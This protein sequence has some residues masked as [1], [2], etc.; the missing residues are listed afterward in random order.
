MVVML[1]AAVVMALA[2]EGYTT[3]AQASAVTVGADMLC[4]AMNEARSSA[5]AQNMTVEVRIYNVPPQ[6]GATPAY[7]ALQ[8]HWI[9]PDGTMPAA[10]LPVRLSSEVVIDATT[11]HSPLIASNT[12]TL[13]IDPADPL[14]NNQARVFHYLPDGS[15]D[16]SPTTN[17]FLTV[18]PANQADPNH[19][20]SNWA[21]VAV[22]ATTG[23]ARIYRP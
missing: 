18:R 9:K 16:L 22:D 8:L 11:T 21:C 13:P 4:D 15:T 1:I 10:A 3:M 23:R 12:E 17:W 19:F 5:V 20:P 2:F 7:D 6:I 14:L